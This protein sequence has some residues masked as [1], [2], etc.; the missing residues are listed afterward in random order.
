MNYFSDQQAQQEEKSVISNKTGIRSRP[1]NLDI[2]DQASWEHT[3]KIEEHK[4]IKF[5]A[6]YIF[7][8]P[9][10]AKI[11]PTLIRRKL[12]IHVSNHG[13]CYKFLAYMEE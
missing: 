4:G 11:I 10:Q 5:S 8:L 13:K 7:H 1:T 12:E 3:G 2:V 9:Q 6:D